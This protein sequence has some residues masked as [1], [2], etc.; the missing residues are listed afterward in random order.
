MACGAQA[1][2]SLEVVFTVSE[3]KGLKGARHLNYSQ[4]QSKMG[5]ILMHPA[6]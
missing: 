5:Y 6:L 3:E 4:I 1:A 2:A